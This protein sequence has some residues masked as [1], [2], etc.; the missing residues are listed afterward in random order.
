[1]FYSQC[2]ED[3]WV[4]ENLRLPEKGF[5]VD[6]GAS[7][8]KDLSNSYYFESI[9]WDGICVEADPSLIS[10]LISE[11]KTVINKAV[12][13]YIGTGTLYKGTLPDWNSL[14]EGGNQ[15]GETIIVP[16]TTLNEIIIQNEIKEINLLSVDVEG[17]EL[18]VL[19]GLSILTPDILIVE[20]TRSDVNELINYLVK[21]YEIV[22]IT[23][24]NIICKKIA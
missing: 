22:H 19:Y 15:S 13:D 6:V 20:H 8:P 1:M 10:N 24:A 11:R 2:E 21:R 7:K 16:V 5:F 3:K 23:R 4:V 14:V 17:A 18:K 12:S 9:G